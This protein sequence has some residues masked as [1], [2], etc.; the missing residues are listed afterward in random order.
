MR[1]AKKAAIDWKRQR[2]RARRSAEVAPELQNLAQWAAGRRAIARARRL[3]CRPIDSAFESERSEQR[4]D[5]FRSAAPVGLFAALAFVVAASA[6]DS[7]DSS[8]VVAARF[9]FAARC[10]GEPH[11]RDAAA[12]AAADSADSAAEFAPQP[13]KPR[14]KLQKPSKQTGLSRNKNF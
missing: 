12:V 11:F 14:K 2:R 8:A 1:P 9:D 7:A 3:S 6:F 5:S 13:Q 10:F 4:T